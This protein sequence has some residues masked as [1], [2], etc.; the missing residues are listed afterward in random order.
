MYFQGWLRVFKIINFEQLKNLI[1]C[2]QIKRKATLELKE[3]FQ[4]EWTK[5]ISPEE[6]VERPIRK[7]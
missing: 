2:D 6:L 4:E 7:S 3:R 5:I 1:M